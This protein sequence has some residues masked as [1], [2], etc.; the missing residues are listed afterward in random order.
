MDI[1]LV[2]FTG[3]TSTGRKIQ[4]AAAS[5]N[6]KKVILELGGKSPTLIFA[7]ADT[8]KA[9]QE[10]ARSLILNSG[11]ICMAGSRIYVQEAVAERFKS[12]FVKVFSAVQKGDPLLPETQQGPQA[13]IFQFERVKGFLATAKSDG[14]GTLLT[15]GYATQEDGEGGYFIEPT[16]YSNAPEDARSQRDEIFGPFVNINTFKAESD[17]VTLANATEYG[18]YASVYTKDLSR[19]LRVAKSIESGAVCVNCTSPTSPHDMPFGGY[20]GSGQGREGFG[21]SLEE[22][23]EVKSVMVKLEDVC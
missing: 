10:T 8:K 23:L 5:S 3:S 19:A 4:T 11:Q 2:N 7:D 1:R 16:V 14:A 15:G 12:A 6:L 9:A 22:Y 20:K 17:A 21:Y 13:D 18:L